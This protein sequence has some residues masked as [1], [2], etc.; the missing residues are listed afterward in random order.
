MTV[1][2]YTPGHGLYTD[3]LILYGLT[4]PLCEV[5]GQQEGEIPAEL[6]RAWSV[7]GFYRLEVQVA[8]YDELADLIASYVADI[9]D[10]MAGELT[11][12]PLGF[13]TEGDVGVFLQALT[14]TGGLADYLRR[15]STPGHAERAGEGREGRG[16]WK[17]VKLPLMPVAG[18]YLHRDLTEASRYPQAPYKACGYCCALA[19]LGLLE[20]SFPILGRGREWNRVITILA[21]DGFTDARYFDLLAAYHI[22]DWEEFYRKLMAVAA[23]AQLPLRVLMKLVVALFSPGL[24]RAMAVAQAR[25]RVLGANLAGRPKA[26]QVRGYQELEITALVHGLDTLYERG[27]MAF[28]ELFPLVRALIEAGEVDA[29][30]SFLD[31]VAIRSLRDLYLFARGAFSTLER[32]RTGREPEKR[33]L[34]GEAARRVRECQKAA[35]LLLTA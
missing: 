29:L 6:I 22:R 25:W 30:E 34:W 18:K 7:G 15:L 27:F 1:E 33:K 21:F 9:E 13:F 11:R 23:A 19:A 8:D 24:V 2:L 5:L 20:A 4:L 26:P 28:S 35:S 14:D 16:R 32:M 12:G 10:R 3:T 17:T 31:F